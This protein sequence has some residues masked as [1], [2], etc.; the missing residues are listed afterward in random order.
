MQSFTS[1]SLFAYYIEVI[2]IARQDTPTTKGTRSNLQLGGEMR[3]E[4]IPGERSDFER[5]WST[6]VT[7]CTPWKTYHLKW[8]PKAQ[9]VVKNAV[10]FATGII[11]SSHTTYSLPFPGVYLKDEATIVAMSAP[12]TGWTPWTGLRENEWCNDSKQ[13]LQR[14]LRNMS[15]CPKTMAEPGVNLKNIYFTRGQ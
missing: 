15:L 1:L 8:E 14:S 9:R 6:Q 7:P 2:L 12:F 3:C 10:S 11:W 5:R 13:Q 4:V